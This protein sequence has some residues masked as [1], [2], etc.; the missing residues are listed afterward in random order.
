VHPRVD[1]DREEKAKGHLQ[2]KFLLTRMPCP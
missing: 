1:C 2:S